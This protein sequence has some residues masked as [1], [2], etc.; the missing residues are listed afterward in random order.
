MSREEWFSFFNTYQPEAD[1]SQ[2]QS[3]FTSLDLNGDDQVDFSEVCD[4]YTSV[5]ADYT[6][7]N[8]DNVVVDSTYE[9]EIRAS[10]CPDS[11]SQI[12][13]AAVGVVQ[14]FDQ[15]AD[16]TICRHEY[17]DFIQVNNVQVAQSDLDNDWY[18]ADF[19]K[20]SLGEAC[21]IVFL[22]TEDDDDS[23]DETTE[24][25]T[26][27]DGTVV[28]IEVDEVDTI[29]QGITDVAEDE[30]SEDDTGFDEAVDDLTVEVEE[31]VVED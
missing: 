7:D 5:Y 18:L 2:L 22:E 10:Y 20:I 15:N 31:V 17:N 1:Q 28:E 23:T 13:Q 11:D 9:E 27:D 26:T 24:D 3:E 4:V 16:W 6:D 8:D 21:R 14:A 19:N 29:N 25:Q 12:F 30:L